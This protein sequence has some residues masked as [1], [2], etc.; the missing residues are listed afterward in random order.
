M[1]TKTMN[2]TAI[3]K[4]SL[5]IFLCFLGLSALVAIVSLLSGEFGH[6]QVKVLATSVAISAASICSMSC[7]AF[8]EKQRL[9]G[10]G[11]SGIIL[12]V[13]SAILLI[14]GMWLEIDIEGYWET[15]ITFII[16]A[17]AFGLAFLLVL[18]ELDDGQKWVQR[19]SSVSIGILALQIAVAVWAETDNE[20]Y[21]RLLGVVA[22]I[23]GIETLAIPMLMKLRKGNGQEKQK[24]VLE[25]LEG[26]IYTDSTG[27]QYQLKEINSE[28]SRRT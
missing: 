20:V 2:Y 15:T 7:A 13:V 14:A 10:P 28:E 25:K 3:R 16:A 6:L 22:I 11:I 21:N 5:K 4:L 9:V 1:G 24:L 17:V 27:K 19:V 8:I 18:P 26:D 23:V 12:S